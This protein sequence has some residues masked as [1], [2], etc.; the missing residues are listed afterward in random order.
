MSKDGN[1]SFELSDDCFTDEEL[2]II[3]GTH[4]AETKRLAE[5]YQ[6]E[7]N[8]DLYEIKE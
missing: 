1:C 4:V 8:G 7:E 6:R 5:E 3:Y 2:D